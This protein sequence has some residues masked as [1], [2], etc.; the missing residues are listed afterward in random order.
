MR[1]KLAEMS[2]EFTHING[3][4]SIPAKWSSS[5]ELMWN[6]PMITWSWKLC[7]WRSQDFHCNFQPRLFLGWYLCFGSWR[8]SPH[9]LKWVKLT[10]GGG[11]AQLFWELPIRWGFTL[12]FT[13]QV[14]TASAIDRI[15]WVFWAW[16]FFFFNRTGAYSQRCCSKIKPTLP[17]SA[18]FNRI[19]RNGLTHNRREGSVCSYRMP[20]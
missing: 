15:F 18:L 2:W 11:L 12:H 3:W 8:P 6:L 1:S 13:V 9:A 17:N 7:S 19:W 10:D 5:R 16:L 4:G 14:P 20:N